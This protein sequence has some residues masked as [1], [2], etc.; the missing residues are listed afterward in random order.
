M[1]N[2]WRSMVA[3]RAAHAKQNSG[4]TPH[5][6]LRFRRNAAAL[7]AGRHRY[8]WLAFALATPVQLICGYKFYRGAWLQVKNGGSNMDTL[9]ALGST[10]AYLFSIYQILRGVHAHVYFMDAAAIIT[11]ISVG[12]WM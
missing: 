1:Q 6:R 10:T 12:H 2:S 4:E 8:Q 9:V 5:L 7:G 11:L 3:L